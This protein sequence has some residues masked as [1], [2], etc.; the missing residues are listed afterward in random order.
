MS[1]PVFYEVS[2][3]GVLSRLRTMWGK[4]RTPPPPEW[5][6]RQCGG[7]HAGLTTDCGG[8]LAGDATKPT[9]IAERGG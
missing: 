7:T 8:R 9:H 4:K 6:C 5:V 3:Q 1:W 2:N